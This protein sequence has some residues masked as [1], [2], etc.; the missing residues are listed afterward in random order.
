MDSDKEKIKELQIR[1]ENL[2]CS[3]FDLKQQIKELED[4]LKRDSQ[5]I[6]YLS[7]Y[8]RC[9]LGKYGEM[10]RKLE[11]LTLPTIKNLVASDRYKIGE[12]LY[13][14]TVYQPDLG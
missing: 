6:E 14:K 2:E 5:L 8:L 11:C 12:Y 7:N 13:D 9:E 1:V 10:F 4:N 3:I